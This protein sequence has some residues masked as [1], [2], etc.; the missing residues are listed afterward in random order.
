MADSDQKFRHLCNPNTKQASILHILCHIAQ[1][2]LNVL[3]C[4]NV[5]GAESENFNVLEAQGDCLYVEAGDYSALLVLEKVLF[6]RV[7]QL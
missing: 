6:G 1:K 5:V 4:L 3:Q 7:A 2:P